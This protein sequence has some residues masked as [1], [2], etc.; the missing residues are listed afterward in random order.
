MRV[1][2]AHTKQSNSSDNLFEHIFRRYAYQG[3]RLSEPVCYVYGSHKAPQLSFVL[4]DLVSFPFIRLGRI[5]LSNRLA[6]P[7]TKLNSDDKDFM[8]VF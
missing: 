1:L 8:V 3:I 6:I 2:Q 5:K 7:S 4:L